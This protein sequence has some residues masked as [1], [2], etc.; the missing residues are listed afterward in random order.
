MA[1]DVHELLREGGDVDALL[2]ELSGKQVVTCVEVGCGIVPVD[3]GERAW[4]ELVGRT[5]AELAAEADQ[6]VRMVCGIPLTLRQ[7]PDRKA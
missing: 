7:A 5:L 1:F 6:V 2:R 4:R 3:A